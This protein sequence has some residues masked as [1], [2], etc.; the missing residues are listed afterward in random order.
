[1]HGLLG[2]LL[3][4]LL[5]IYQ[6]FC[7]MTGH[8]LLYQT[9]LSTEPHNFC[10]W[11]N[12]RSVTLSTSAIS[13]ASDYLGCWPQN[14]VNKSDMPLNWIEHR[15]R[16]TMTC[17]INKENCHPSEGIFKHIVRLIYVRIL[18]GSFVERVKR[19][20]QLGAFLTCFPWGE[21]LCI[22]QCCCKQCLYVWQQA[23]MCNSAALTNSFSP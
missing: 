20:N 15:H 4:R 13:K 12:S 1:M 21:D 19:N 16:I 7:H 17:G 6:H 23:W 11:N 18:Q 3:C 9:L 22:T 5:K 8:S 10:H 14:R 2:L